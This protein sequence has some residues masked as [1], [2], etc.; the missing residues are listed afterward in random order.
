MHAVLELCFARVQCQKVLTAS[1]VQRIAKPSFDWRLSSTDP[2]IDSR[3]FL[4]FKLK[5]RASLSQAS[6][7]ASRIESHAFLRTESSSF[8]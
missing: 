2:F 4:L 8:G 7:K 1:T 6:A 5:S 3:N